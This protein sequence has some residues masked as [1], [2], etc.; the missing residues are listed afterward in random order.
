MVGTPERQRT[1]RHRRTAAILALRAI[2]SVSPVRATDRR[3]ERRRIARDRRYR[4]R[5]AVLREM[6]QFLQL[7]QPRRNRRAP[8]QGT[9]SPEPAIVVSSDLSGDE[10]ATIAAPCDRPWFVYRIASQYR[11]Q[12]PISAA[13]S[14]S[15]RPWTFGCYGRVCARAEKSNVYRES[16]VLLNRLQVPPLRQLTPPPALPVRHLTPPPEPEVDWVEL[17]QVV[18]HFDAPQLP[19]LQQPV[20]EP[21]PQFVPD[22]FMPP[23][24][25]PPVDWAKIAHALFVLAEQEHEARMN[26]PN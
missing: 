21:F 25:L 1:T 22:N 3:A 14:A 24:Q 7:P 15:G 10:H 20:V 6:C 16:Y 8:V 18:A 5:L 12:T 23:K 17:E 9:A 19:L 26:N 11:H 4:E 13:R 2:H